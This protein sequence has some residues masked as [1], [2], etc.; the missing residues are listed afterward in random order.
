ML[1]PSTIPLLGNL[2]T[3]EV[4]RNNPNIQYFGHVYISRRDRPA[5]NFINE[6]STCADCD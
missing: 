1:P 6:F 5:L 4:L 3:S 2:R